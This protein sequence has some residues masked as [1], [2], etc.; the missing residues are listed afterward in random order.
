MGSSRP[1]LISFDEIKCTIT[2]E[3]MIN[4]TLRGYLQT[5]QDH[6]TQ[7]QRHRWIL[8]MAEGVELIHSLDIIHYDLSPHNLLLDQNLELKIA[9]FGCCA[10]DGSPSLARGSARFYPPRASWLS[11]ITVDHERFA[12]GSSMYEVLTGGAPFHDVSTPYVRNL[13]RL[14]QLRDLADVDMRDI[15]RDCWLLQG[16]SSQEVRQRTLAAAQIRAQERS[17]D[18]MDE[19]ELTGGVG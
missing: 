9:D 8:A 4:G 16:H 6:I 19:D 13:C 2:M 15:I 1:Q 3:Y 10:T 5:S 18:R 7:G 14:K 17:Q 12:L 11:P